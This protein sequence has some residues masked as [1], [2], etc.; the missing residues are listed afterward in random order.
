MHNFREIKSW[1]KSRIVVK[2]IYVL[3]RKFPREEL[4]GLTSQIRRAAIS[5]PANIAEGSGRNTNKDFCKFLGYAL[6]SAYEVE[7]ELILSYDLGFISKDE[8]SEVGEK[9]R[10]VEKLIYGLIRKYEK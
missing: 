7:T 4:Y 1:K 2:E 5:I 8:V 3:T 6:A 10:E 9:V